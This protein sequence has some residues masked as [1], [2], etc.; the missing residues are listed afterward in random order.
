MPKSSF[1]MFPVDEELKNKFKAT[2]Y[3]EGCALKD[4]MVELM[5]AYMESVEIPL[6]QA[7]E[8]EKKEEED[9]EII[10]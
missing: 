9:I 4:K 10:P 5:T 3:G 7:P 1:V 2:C 6:A 8:Q